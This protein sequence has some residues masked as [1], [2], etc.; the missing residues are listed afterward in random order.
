[1]SWIMDIPTDKLRDALI[2]QVEKNERLQ[3][4]LNQ[5]HKD[6]SRERK[7]R[8]SLSTRSPNYIYFKREWMGRPCCSEHGAMLKVDALGMYRCPT[9][10][11]G[12]STRELISFILTEWD[13]VYIVK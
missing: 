5:A 6:I 13:G 3:E 8:A 11:V 4:Q 9:C 10:N 12:V 7:D 1:M 2:K